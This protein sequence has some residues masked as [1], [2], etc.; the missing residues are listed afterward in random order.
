M[1][2][3]QNVT[4]QTNS[5][6]LS[7][8]IVFH[9][10]DGVAGRGA[11]MDRVKR[12]R[13][14]RIPWHA[15]AWLPICEDAIDAAHVEL[16]A[17]GW[18]SAG[19]KRPESTAVRKDAVKL[20]SIRLGL[21][22]TD[23]DKLQMIAVSAR[24]AW[25]RLDDET[26]FLARARLLMEID[27][28]LDDAGLDTDERARTRRNSR[29]RV[30]KSLDELD[31]CADV[32]GLTQLESELGEMVAAQRTL[33][34]F[35]VAV[36]RET[37]ARIAGGTI[38]SVDADT[39]IRWSQR[40]ATEPTDPAA[41]VDQVVAHESERRRHPYGLLSA[42]LHPLGALI[43]ERVE[44]PKQKDTDDA[45]AA[46]VAA[47]L[48]QLIWLDREGK[49][50]DDIGKPPEEWI[51]A[52]VK[53]EEGKARR[54]KSSFGAGIPVISIESGGNPESQQPIEIPVHDSIDERALFDD[55]SVAAL[56]HT[57]HQ[58]LRTGGGQL[59]GAWREWHTTLTGNQRRKFYEGFDIS[60]LVLDRMKR[61]TNLM[62]ASAGS[63]QRDVALGLL[64]EMA[65]TAPDQRWEWVKPYAFE[66]LR[67]L[68][69]T[70]R[71]RYDVLPRESPKEPVH[72]AEP[73]HYRYLHRLV[74][75]DNA[76][77]HPLLRDGIVT[78]LV[79]GALPRT[80]DL[81]DRIRDAGPENGVHL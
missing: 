33:S 70:W 48:T 5:E 17:T 75:G 35:R 77:S 16:E 12:E 25:R 58:D 45:L 47:L 46:A 6:A 28:L 7:R 11:A 74:R 56:V 34:E 66:A 10:V 22:V 64:Y 55:G 36:Q 26:L 50:A 80:M 49:S 43:T 15:D 14:I 13:Q 73:A 57:L 1:R 42:E 71:Q 67:Y 53:A 60:V 69:P 20:A 40:D 29:N 59:G 37:E 61:V 76:Y 38:N 39:A 24:R 72:E 32:G 31:L 78:R 52:A 8:P 2:N 4:A 44:H 68:D 18:S 81:L 65:R 21:D 23:T 51:A 62:R 9:H 54:S 63:G 79:V 41:F 27:G 3:A 30:D 19:V